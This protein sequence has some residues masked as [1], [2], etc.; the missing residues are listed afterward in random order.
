LR[1]TGKVFGLIMMVIFSLQHMFFYVLEWWDPR[2][3]IERVP[4][5]GRRKKE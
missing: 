4:L 1:A 2:E 5:E 3:R